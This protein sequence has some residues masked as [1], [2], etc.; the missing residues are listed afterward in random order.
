MNPRICRCCG[1]PIP[2]SGNN[3]SRNPNVCASCS[4][5]AD[6]ID[7]PDLPQGADAGQNLAVGLENA[8]DSTTPA[9]EDA[10]AE[11]GNLHALWR[12]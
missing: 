9:L 10:T 7:E 11:S 2:E 8:A 3:L 12:S 1:E 4:S 5:M 6:G